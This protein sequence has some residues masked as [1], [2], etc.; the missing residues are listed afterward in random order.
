MKLG[1]RW[2]VG[3]QPPAAVP[4]ELHTPLREAEERLGAAAGSSWTLT[5]LEGRP[6]ATLDDGTVV[7]LDG[8]AESSPASESDDD[9]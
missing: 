3:S 7:T 1:T 6:L 2:T 5:W 4:A 8:R 9:W